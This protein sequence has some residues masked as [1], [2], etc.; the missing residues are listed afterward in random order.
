MNFKNDYVDTYELEQNKG[1]AA[2]TASSSTIKKHLH[3]YDNKHTFINIDRTIVDELRLTENDSF[4]EE[5]TKD[6]IL[7][8]RA[9][10]VYNNSKKDSRPTTT[11]KPGDWDYRA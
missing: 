11:T 9:S 5:I 10:K 3:F 6:G 1:N 7:L 2:A 8:R 4:I